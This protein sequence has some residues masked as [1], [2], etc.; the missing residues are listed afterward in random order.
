MNAPSDH[1][2]ATALRVQIGSNGVVDEQTANDI[3]AMTLFDLGA[4]AVGETRA[5]NQLTLTAGFAMLDCAQAADKHL[6]EELGDLIG[7]TLV[8]QIANSTWVQAQR[9]AI[10]PT[11]VG[12]WHIRA[13]WHT[14]PANVAPSRDIVI[15]PGEAFGHGGHPTTR[16][17]IELMLRHLTPD[18]A[19]SVTVVDLGTGTGVAAIIAAR[20]GAT[21]R[22]IEIDEAAIDVARTNIACNSNDRFDD[23]ANKIELIH[24][25]AAD[26]R[27][28]PTDLV[29]A[30]VTLD[31]QR[32]L[33]E[34]L[35]VAANLVTSGFLCRQVGTM[36]SLYVGHRPST[37]RIYGEWAAVNF[38]KNA[39][40]GR[41][42]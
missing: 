40:L 7:S 27:I 2:M 38:S 13:P 30:N 4:Q 37:I 26:A 33:A 35:S 19:A 29:L 10:E 22:A 5:N 28:E 24:G 32:L 21:V 14:K 16:L 41:K 15:D 18:S 17:T 39:A 42:N 1:N 36:D 23:V 12:P 25:D 6:R 31:I 8:E 3:V 20:L 9:A 11:T 34:R